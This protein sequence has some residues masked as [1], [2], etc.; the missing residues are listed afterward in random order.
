MILGDHSQEKEKKKNKLTRLDWDINT[1]YRS[2][3]LSGRLDWDINTARLYTQPTTK[4]TK[5]ND[6][7]ATLKRVTNHR[8][9]ARH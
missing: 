5:T 7:S 3:K 9:E 8:R 6:S 4:E 1:G 2:I